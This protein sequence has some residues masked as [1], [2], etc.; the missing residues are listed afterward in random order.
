MNETPFVFND[1][2]GEKATLLLH[3]NV[4]RDVAPET[5]CLNQSCPICLIRSGR[6][7]GDS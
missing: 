3:K 2:R 4:K 1:T 5:E 7:L 6:L